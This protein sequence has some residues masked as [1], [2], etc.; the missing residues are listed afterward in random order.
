M[1]GP[2]AWGLGVMLT[3]PHRKNL[4]RNI[5]TAILGQERDGRGV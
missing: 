4:L 1:G 5:H 3:T 2:P